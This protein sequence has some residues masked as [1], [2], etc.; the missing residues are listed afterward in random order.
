M[1][2]VSATKMIYKIQELIIFEDNAVADD[3]NKYFVNAVPHL[4]IAQNNTSETHLSKQ[5]TQ[6]SM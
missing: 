6:Y 4:N 5:I 2:Q 3:F 1:T